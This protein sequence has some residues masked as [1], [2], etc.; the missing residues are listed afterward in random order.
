MKYLV[1]SC[2]FENNNNEIFIDRDPTY[3]G[4]ILNYLRDGKLVRPE[5]EK[6]NEELE[7]EIKFYKIFNLMNHEMLSVV[8]E[9][10]DVGG[11]KTFSYKSY[12]DTN[13]LIYWLGTNCGKKPINFTNPITRKLI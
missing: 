5:D 9:D 3:F 1:E 4:K 12:N 11:S 13:G 2:N 10:G 8:L 7:K 6:A